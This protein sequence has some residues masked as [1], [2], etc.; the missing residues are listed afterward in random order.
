MADLAGLE[1]LRVSVWVQL[2]AQSETNRA[3]AT[4]QAAFQPKRSFT[5]GHR[6]AGM[7]IEGRWV[8]VRDPEVLA[9]LEKEQ[10]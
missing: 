3:V 10:H 4:R 9:E 5:A 1:A 6:S 7:E 8:D 2:A